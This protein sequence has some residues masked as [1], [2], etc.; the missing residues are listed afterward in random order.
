MAQNQLGVFNLAISSIGSRGIK[1][2]SVD[3]ASPHAEECRLWY[4]P[5]RDQVFRAAFWP[6]NKAY[7]R[8]AL[9]ATR[10]SAADW[11]ATDPEPGWSFVYAAP[12]DMLRPRYLTTYER[13]TTGVYDG[14][15]GDVPVIY[16]SAEN[17]IL[18]YTKDQPVVSLWDSQLYTAVAM[19]L[20]YFVALPLHGKRVFADRA[21][22]QANALLME[23]RLSAANEEENKI[24]QLPPWLQARG[25][26]GQPTINQFTYPYGP[27][28]GATSGGESAR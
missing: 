19:A 8:L 14:G 7:Q 20:G 9:I 23:A 27:L 17:P 15:G 13:F 22:E 25:F 6:V 2:S 11:V 4:E 16:T 1:L 10:D 18:V 24:D 12:S 5:V 28:I 21:L 26:Q 3:E